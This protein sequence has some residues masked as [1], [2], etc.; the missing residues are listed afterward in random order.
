MV[1]VESMWSFETGFVVVVVQWAG[2][3]TVL[4]EGSEEVNWLCRLATDL[5]SD[6]SVS[7]MSLSSVERAGGLGAGVGG[8]R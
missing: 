4:L 7:V 6:A 8:R 1:T 3:L 5:C 2:G